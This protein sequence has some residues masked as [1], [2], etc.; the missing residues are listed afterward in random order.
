MKA[1]TIALSAVI[2]AF[3]AILLSVGEFFP[4]LSLG[5]AFLAGVAV[6]VPLAKRSYLGAVLCII[7]AALITML[8][9][10]FTRF[11]AI[12]PFAFF[13]GV[14]PI[15]NRVQAER[16]WNRWLLLVIKDIWFVGFAVGYY[17]LF[18]LVLFE[19]NEDLNRF[20]LPIII[21]GGAIA[22]VVYDYL[23]FYFQRYIDILIKRMKL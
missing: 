2:A 19:N 3:C 11:E 5:A 18:N 14:Q 15:V 1:K 9:T 16:N 10:G 22:Y 17:F 6:M 21:V 8:I 7:A 12:V 23:S 13:F 4:T 20:A